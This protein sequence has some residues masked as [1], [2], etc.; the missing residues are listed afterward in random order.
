MT[1]PLVAEFLRYNA[2]ANGEL[3]V[4]CEKLSSE[5][6]ERR[7]EGTY[8]TKLPA[9]MAGVTSSAIESGWDVNSA[10]G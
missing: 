2:W 7:A 8:G 10:P 6:L 9:S 1:E 3:L 4:A 5:Q